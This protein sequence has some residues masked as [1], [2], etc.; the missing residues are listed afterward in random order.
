[1]KIKFLNKCDNLR[2]Q[3]RQV[4]I[5]PPFLAFT[6]SGLAY[7]YKLSLCHVI[8][9]GEKQPRSV[10]CCGLSFALAAVIAHILCIIFIFSFH[11]LLPYDHSK[12]S[13]IWNR[14]EQKLFTGR[15]KSYLRNINFF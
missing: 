2:Q 6:W 1:M 11:C 5:L 7:F 10:E 4:M 12:T 14:E 3:K 8:K 9:V 13:F 15:K